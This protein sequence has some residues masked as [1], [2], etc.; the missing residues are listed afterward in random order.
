MECNIIKAL[1]LSDGLHIGLTLVCWCFPLLSC[2]LRRRNFS[3]G[4]RG[5]LGLIGRGSLLINNMLKGIK[6]R[7][8]LDRA[9]PPAPPVVEKIGG[10]WHFLERGEGKI[11][12]LIEIF[13]LHFLRQRLVIYYIS[14]NEF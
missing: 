2:M 7:A 8:A 10:V 9:D 14:V 4:R 12:Q 6:K 3:I 13:G 1:E 11:L 5:F